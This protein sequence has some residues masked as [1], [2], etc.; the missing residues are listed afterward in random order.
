MKVRPLR[1]SNLPMNNSKRA[2]S[3]IVGASAA[4]AA[5]SLGAPSAKAQLTSM[6]QSGIQRPT[7]GITIG[8]TTMAKGTIQ[9][10]NSAGTNDSF[11]VGTSTSIAANASASSTSDYS[12]TSVASFDMGNNNVDGPG[13][14][15]VINQ[16]IGKSQNSNASSSLETDL[17]TDLAKTA[18]TAAEELTNKSFKAVNDTTGA[19]VKI[20]TLSIDF[21]LEGSDFDSQAALSGVSLYQFVGNSWQEFEGSSADGA[22]P[23]ETAG[24]QFKSAYTAEN[25]L[26]Y[27]E[28]FSKVAAEA[29]F[30]AS[31]SGIISGEFKK[32]AGNTQTTNY[33]SVSQVNA[34]TGSIVSN[35]DFTEVEISD[36]LKSEATTLLTSIGTAADGTEFTFD[37]DADGDDNAATGDV[38]TFT[39][40]STAGLAAVDTLTEISTSESGQDYAVDTTNNSTFKLDTVV[41]QNSSFTQT[42]PTTNIVSVQGINSE[43]SI[44]SDDSAEFSANI[45]KDLSSATVSS[46]TASGSATGNVTTTASA[47]ASSSSFINS[48]VQA[49]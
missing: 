7:A 23:G 9:Y 35:S 28:T 3:L 40:G 21:D 31:G 12:V 19:E 22:T 37:L 15:S 17:A 43:N 39:K 26:N 6:L 10:T 45:T 25:T 46:G 29:S 18:A 32:N 42:A 13:G 34:G 33:E 38:L 47:S 4:L 16:Q 27:D 49:Y 14:L 41:T 48:F 24:S 30:E 44:V 11:S 5:G 2:L 20:S 36:T 8:Q 1:P